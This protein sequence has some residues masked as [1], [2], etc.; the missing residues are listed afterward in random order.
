MRL[1]FS[2]NVTYRYATN[3]TQCIHNYTIKLQ[4]IIKFTLKYN[5]LFLCNDHSLLHL[6]AKLKSD[7][8]KLP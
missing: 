5:F 1:N 8:N 6:V 2:S 4:K 3:H 7:A